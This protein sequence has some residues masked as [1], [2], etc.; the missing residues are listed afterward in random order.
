QMSATPYTV[1]LAVRSRW[2]NLATRVLEETR[3][4][5]RVSVGTNQVLIQSRS[6]D[7]ENL[8]PITWASSPVR[9]QE[10]VMAFG[11][12]TNEFGSNQFDTLT[13]DKSPFIPNV[14]ERTCLGLSLYVPANHTTFRGCSEHEI[15]CNAGESF[16]YTPTEVTFRTKRQ[17][18]GSRNL[19]VQMAAYSP[20]YF[21]K[22][23]SSSVPFDVT[24][25]PWNL[26]KYF[27]NVRIKVPF[28]GPPLER[29]LW[30]LSIQQ[31][32]NW[33]GLLLPVSF[34][35]ERYDDPPER[36]KRES[37]TVIASLEGTLVSIKQGAIADISPQLRSHL[38][39][40]DLRPQR[41]LHGNMAHYQAENGKWPALGTKEYREMV[42]VSRAELAKQNGGGSSPRRSNVVL[43]TAFLLVFPAA[44]VLLL[45][46]LVSWISF[47]KKR[48]QRGQT[49]D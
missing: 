30:S 44:F 34:R 47:R 37:G 14:D 4:E 8:V 26:A 10:W 18:F 21:Y 33:S 3:A 46:A 13:I 11:R 12:A 16:G 9:A 6:P 22:S 41:E 27:A 25:L 1:E 36:A 49:M 17:L 48:V 38:S 35:Y 28:A 43:L 39:V 40:F 15:W 23:A 5:L 20:K 2:L 29:K 19:P 7:N 32:T 45:I 24:R 42:R 31:Y